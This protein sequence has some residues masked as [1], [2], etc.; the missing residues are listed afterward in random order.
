MRSER[1]LARGRDVDRRCQFAR[2]RMLE[3]RGQLGEQ[4]VR[5]LTVRQARAVERASRLK[6]LRIPSLADEGA[7][8][9]GHDVEPEQSAGERS[10][11]HQ[12]FRVR[13]GGRR[14][15]TP[16]RRTGRMR[17]PAASASSSILDLRSR[18]S[19]TRREPTRYPTRFAIVGCRVA[20]RLPSGL[21]S[22]ATCRAG[23]R[24]E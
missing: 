11:R 14:E 13:I 3:I 12:H 20:M 15:T 2:Y 4:V 24:P 16:D 17:R 5:V 18:T 22:Y 9:A 19:A 23:Q 8:E 1:R 6:Q 21:P 7:L 10:Q